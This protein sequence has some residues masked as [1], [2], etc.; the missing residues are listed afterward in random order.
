MIRSLAALALLAVATLASGWVHPGISGYF[1]PSG[2]GGGGGDTAFTALHT[3][4]ISPT[5]NDGLAG[6][7]SGTAWA[8]PNHAV[9]CGDVIIAAAGTYSSGW[10]SWGTV[11][12]C[13]STSGGIDGTGGVY[14]AVILCGGSD[15]EACKMTLSG[16]TAFNVQSNYW[17]VEGFKA[18]TG[19][20]SGAAFMANAPSSSVNTHHV[21]FI[22]DVAYNTGQGFGDNGCV[23]GCQQTAGPGGTDYYAI[24]G[25]IAQNAAQDSICLGAIDV[26]APTA[27]DTNPG[28][29]ILFY[30]NF[31][32]AH[33]SSGCTA[34]DIED[35]MFDTWSARNYGQ[36]GVISNNMGWS[37]SRECIQ[38]FEQNT[39]SPT[40][41]NNIYNNT[42]FQNNLHIGSDFLDG[43]I[44]TIR[45][46][47]T[48]T[49]ILTIINNIAYQPNSSS[50]S[51]NAGVFNATTTFTI[52]GSGAQ[53]IFK[54]NNTSCKISA[55]NSGF[56]VAGSSTA[57]YGVNTYVNPAFNN[58]SDLLT[59]WVGV[60]SCTGK[61]NVAQCMGYDAYTQTLT[62]NTPIYDL[63]PTAG[64]MAGKGYQ[65][66]ST[67]CNTNAD[68]PAWLKGVVYLHWTGSAVVQ[69]HGLV[70]T[71]CGL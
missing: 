48:I 51:T 35:Y 64:G 33:S 40:P 55:C 21:A 58:T 15:L 24:V 65:L 13:P 60:P 16:G 44:N 18:T 43:E 38:I 27:Q 59:N 20:A 1:Q 56:D 19:G 28:T 50:N 11:S 66:P 5:G 31:S 61:E 47:G 6:T 23:G 7:S 54:A 26:V 63:T 30:G 2:G 9:N 14:F 46:S 45:S 4:Y 39:N 53:N 32:Y 17:A 42:C 34:S 69:R 37:A 12:N 3:Y 25:N 70:T 49:Y 67:A 41:V 71:P 68:F 36:T 29:H 10:S 52:G 57:A 8:T 62:A 22:N